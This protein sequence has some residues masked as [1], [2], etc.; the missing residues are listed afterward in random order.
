MKNVNTVGDDH[1]SLPIVSPFRKWVHNIWIENCEEHLTYG[2]RPYKIDEYWAIY[3]WWL[4]RQY[5][6]KEQIK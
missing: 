6:Q 2:E 5:K 4:K 1:L 3:K